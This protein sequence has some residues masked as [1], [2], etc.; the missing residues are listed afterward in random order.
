MCPVSACASGNQAIE[1]AFLKI[2]FGLS[3]A[4]LAGGTEASIT[5]IA[6]AGYNQ[7]KALSIRND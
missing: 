1:E 3:E 6:Y 7:I 2:K 4:M 5:P